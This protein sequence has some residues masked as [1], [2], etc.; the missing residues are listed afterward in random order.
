MLLLF[1]LP[2]M[3]FF[4]FSLADNEENAAAGGGGPFKLLFVCCCFNGK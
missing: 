2:R 1:R 4:K 3:S